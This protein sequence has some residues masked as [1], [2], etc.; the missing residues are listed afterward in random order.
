VKKGRRRSVKVANEPRESNRGEGGLKFLF[1]V[2][3]SLAPYVM[4]WDLKKKGKGR[5]E[6]GRRLLLLVNVVERGTH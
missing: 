6:D 3:E 2:F 4:F 5:G 1:S